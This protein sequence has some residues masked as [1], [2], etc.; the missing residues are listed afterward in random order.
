MIYLPS[1]ANFSI[2]ISSQPPDTILTHPRH[3]A[4]SDRSHNLMTSHPN[5]APSESYV[6]N[7][8]STCTPSHKRPSQQMN[9][10]FALQM[11]PTMT[12]QAW[13]QKEVLANPCPQ[14]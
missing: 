12:L 14:F 5:D 2:L 1:L 13:N 10:H 7:P 11:P 4:A 3:S 9:D 8:L 6:L